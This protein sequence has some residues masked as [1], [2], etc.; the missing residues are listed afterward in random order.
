ML[1]LAVSPIVIW[2][3][4]RYGDWRA[5]AEGGWG[6]LL[7]FV[8]LIAA[9][10]PIFAA[11]ALVK[12][13]PQ[14]RTARRRS[15]GRWMDVHGYVEERRERTANWV[16]GRWEVVPHWWLALYGLGEREPLV[17]R[18]AVE[19]DEACARQCGPGQVIRVYGADDDGR[20]V[21]AAGDRVIWPKSQAQ[22]LPVT[23][24]SVERYGRTP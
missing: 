12:A 16:F 13:L 3:C 1:S 21:L 24:R 8:V 2:A 15:L 9:L 5:P 19:V 11:A 23:A 4:I 17:A 14:L 22:G 18:L 20:V 10:L 6:K 7:A